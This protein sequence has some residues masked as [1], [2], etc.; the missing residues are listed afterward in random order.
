MVKELIL[1]WL[2][3]GATLRA[4]QSTL[5]DWAAE[6]QI[7]LAHPQSTPVRPYE[8][9]Q[10]EALELLLDN[11]R[12]HGG[13]VAFV[14]TLLILQVAA[15]TAAAVPALHAQAAPAA[16]VIVGRV[17]DAATEAPIPAMAPEFPGIPSRFHAGF[18]SIPPEDC[19]PPVSGAGNRRQPVSE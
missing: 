8:P 6:Q 17:L 7:A 14:L 19:G 9:S 18:P 5:D 13:G 16:G 10:S 4:H 2:S 11:A 1:V 12:T 3:S 15:A